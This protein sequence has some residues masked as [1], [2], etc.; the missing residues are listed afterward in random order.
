MH[1]KFWQAGPD[2]SSVP[3]IE[4]AYVRLTRFG[5]AKMDADKSIESIA[6]VDNRN[7]K[8]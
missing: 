5:L 2:T 8:F 4:R 3:A 6:F 1:P 7:F